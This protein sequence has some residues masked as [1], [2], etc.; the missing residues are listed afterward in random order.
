MVHFNGETANE[1]AETLVQKVHVGGVIYY[2]WANGLHSPKQ[3]SHLS[4]GLQKL[5]SRNRL[6]IPLF[7]AVDQEGG[8][9]ARLERG[10]TVFPGNKA[11]GM[12]GD[13]GLAE[14]SALAIGQEC[15][16]VGVNMNLSPVVDVNN[17]PRNPV[18]G[19]R[20]FG[21]T[22]ETVISFAKR[23][24]Q[25]YQKAGIVSCLKHFPG[26]GDVEVDSH[27]V[28]PVIQK[29][30]RQLEQ[31]ELLPFS[32]LAAQAD[33]IMTAHIIVP[34]IDSANCATLSTDVLNVLRQ[35][36]GFKGVIIADSL[37]MEGV[38]KNA[39]SV[40]DVAIRAF[41][42]GCDILMLGGKQLTGAHASLELKTADVERIHTS[43]VNAVKN[44]L[45]SEAR[46]NE[47]VQR[48][49]N[50]KSKY[51][52][53]NNLK[54]RE[55]DQK[56][57]QNFCS[58]RAII[59][60]RQGASESKNYEANPTQSKTDSSG[61]FGISRTEKLD[62]TINSAE[63]QLLA[64]KIALLALRVTEKKALAYHSFSA[65]K[66]AVFAPGI[67]RDSI[68][69]T[70]LLQLGKETYPLFF[71]GL[72]LSEGEIKAAHEAAKKADILIFCSYNAWKN[73]TQL[74]LIQSLF[75]YEKPFILI[76]LRDPLDETLV[77]QADLLS[78]TLGS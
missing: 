36:I 25:G 37:V 45:I 53:R 43:L 13:P 20:S 23:A 2:N 48:I 14:Q 54:N 62:L 19:I 1:D 24:M 11:L 59:A 58:E 33:A 4:L 55:I 8:V 40:D 42:A 51:L 29:S 17:N 28:L 16:V 41:N 27:E 10:F 9:V 7:I 70:S 60:E 71:D 21:D 34:A 68:D 30:K 26:H 77:P 32:E 65:Y 31:V 74:T 57:P 75:S 67:T 72:N 61:C 46:L 47:A 66:I 69:Q 38:L 39:S 78:S 49:L 5:A 63:H 6:A 56:D 35:E 44:G 64:E 15:S 50:L 73:S 22:T 52:Y 18:I 3:V 76:S 12:T